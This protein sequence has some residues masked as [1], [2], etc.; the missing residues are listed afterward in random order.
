MHGPVWAG[1]CQR[2]GAV[3][4]PGKG[5]AVL[6]DM[7]V[8]CGVRAAS[9]FASQLVTWFRVNKR[10]LPWRRT[11]DPYAIW[12]SE[13]M[14]Q[15]TQVKTVIPYWDRWMRELPTIQSLARAKGERVLK[16]W[17]GL[18]YYSRARNLQKA[19]QQIVAMHGGIFP[20]SYEAILEL[21]GIGRYT[22]GAI[23]SIA[24]GLPT[25]IVDGNVARVLAR[26]LGLGGDPKSRETSVA[27]WESAERLVR[28]AREQD[29]CRELNEGMMELGA[30]ICVPTKPNCGACPVSS[31]CFA[32]KN[33]ATARF[34][35]IAP[36]RKSETRIFRAALITVGEKILLR[37]RVEGEV[38]GGF[39]ELPN[40]EVK[41][42]PPAETLHA[43]IGKAKLS[44]TRLCDVKHTIM[45]HRITTEVFEVN[46]ARFDGGKLFGMR[47]LSAIPLVSAHRK[48]LLKT[49]YLKSLI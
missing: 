25:P 5:V 6:P 14:L 36:R 27:L 26:Y 20:N 40:M 46:G 49:G 16:L 45:S 23:G 47:E 11:R 43:L 12:V 41:G 29:A 4:S 48:A 2:T 7:A 32:F 22:A 39:W 18:G 17:E 44:F 38:N 33:D 35:E 42:E 24:F 34:P 30:T 3:E 15:Q 10:D 13:V 21:P 28:A 1:G 8:E 19:A 31:R 37:Q 9:R